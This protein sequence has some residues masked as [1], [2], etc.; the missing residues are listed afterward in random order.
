MSALEWMSFG[1]LMQFVRTHFPGDVNRNGSVAKRIIKRFGMREAEA[2]IRGAHAL[3][4]E[5][6]IALNAKDGFARRWAVS[7]FW[8]RM[9]HTPGPTLENIGTMLKK[10]GLV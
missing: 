3:G 2:M 4:W 6:I 8:D 7:V 5:D 1:Q 9:K 10:A